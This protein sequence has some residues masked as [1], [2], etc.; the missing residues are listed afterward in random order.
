MAALR[1]LAIVVGVECLVCLFFAPYGL[2][3]TAL[4]LLFAL[5]FVTV[6]WTVGALSSTDSRKAP[7][8]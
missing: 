1:W 4:V 2:W 8:P 5:C 7:T 3:S 6:S